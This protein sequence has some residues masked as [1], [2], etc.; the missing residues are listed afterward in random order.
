VV[1]GIAAAGDI[2][3]IWLTWWLGDAAGVLIFTPLL[4]AWGRQLSVSWRPARLAEGLLLSLV[5][6]FT[7]QLVF[8]GWFSFASNHYPLAFLPLP[9]LMWAALRFGRRGATAGIALT[10]V[11][12]IW[13]TVL[14]FGP[15]VIGDLNASLLLLQF[16][17]GVTGLSTLALAV[18]LHERHISQQRLRLAHE[19]MEQ[20]IQARTRELAEANARLQQEM[21]ER[22]QTQDMATSLGRILEESLN[23]VYIFAADT[24]RF[25]NVNQSA[26]DNLGYTMEELRQL[27]PVDIKPEMSQ[28]IFDRV[29]AP[30]KKGCRRRLR[31]ETVHSRKDGSRYPVEVHLQL[32]SLGTRQVFVAIIIDITER[33]QS[34]ARLR[35]AATVFDNSTECI[36]IT[37]ANSSI[38]GVNKAFTTVTGYTEAEVLGEKPGILK[39]RRHYHDSF[40]AIKKSIPHTGPWQGEIWNRRKNGMEFPAWMSISEVRDL[41]GV[42]TDYVCVFS[43]ISAVKNAQAQINHLAYH[44]PLTDLPNRILF[45]DRLAHSI[46]FSRRADKRM[47]LLFIDIDSF[48]NINDT[49]GHAAGDCLLQEVARRLVDSVREVDTVARL[50]GDEFTIILE[51]INE[52]QNVITIVERILSEMSSPFVLG[53]HKGLVS[54]SIGIS[55]FPDD[56]VDAATLLNQADYAMYQAKKDGGR[57]F[58]FYLEGMLPS[59]NNM[60][61][62]EEIRKKAN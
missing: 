19:Q 38:I 44:D 50:S 47:A 54:A 5:L 25:F 23:E 30:L 43:N 61:T 1:T 7:T 9:V 52:Q 60:L 13:G 3:S 20:R 22:I 56:G 58:S 55:I 27:T 46:Q 10:A 8:G 16:Y 24:L 28:E 29:V 59:A 11:L 33:H 26:R 45:N 48:K 14:G 31:Y 34:Q 62:Q 4:L 40:E 36:M 2:G 35:Q 53:E 12:A 39:S 57:R 41:A 37:D 17:M 15:F 18:I 51:G 6:V 21:D 49:Y 42:V 32:T